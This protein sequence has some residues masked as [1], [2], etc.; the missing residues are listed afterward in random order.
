VRRKRSRPLWWPISSRG[1]LLFYPAL[2]WHQVEALDAFNVMINYWWNAAPAYMDSPQLTLMHALLS[3]RDRPQ[4]EKQAWRASVRPLCLRTVRTGRR[5]PAETAR[6]DLGPMDETKARR[7]RAY[8]L[9][10][11]NR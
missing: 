2:W 8:L 3:L 9:N 7:L 1:D 5:A 11:L 6:G 4:T 10:K